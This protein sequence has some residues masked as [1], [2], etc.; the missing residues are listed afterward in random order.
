[1]P[2]Y[3]Q[4]KIYKIVSTNSTKCFIGFTCQKYLCKIYGNHR[5][6]WRKQNNKYTSRHIFDAGGTCKIVLIQSFP[7]KYQ[8]ELKEREK[9]YIELMNCV[10]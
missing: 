6:S 9:F 7:C 1:M 8:Y 10:N 2:D 4:G 3:S 5:T